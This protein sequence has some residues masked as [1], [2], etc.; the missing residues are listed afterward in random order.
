M[1]VVKNI[2]DTERCFSYNRRVI[3]GSRF[4]M[5]FSPVRPGENRAGSDGMRESNSVGTLRIKEER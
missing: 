2:I 4:D 1:Q 3:N 5:G